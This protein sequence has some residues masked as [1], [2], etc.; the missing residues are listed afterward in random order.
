LSAV[1]NLRFHK[2]WT[3]CDLLRSYDFLKKDLVVWSC[4]KRCVMTSKSRNPHNVS[5]SRRGQSLHIKH[6]A[7]SR[8]VKEC[9]QPLTKCY[10]TYTN[11]RLTGQAVLNPD[12]VLGNFSHS[13]NFCGSRNSNNININNICS[14]T[15]SSKTHSCVFQACMTAHRDRSLVNKTNRQTEFQVY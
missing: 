1:M 10:D 14:E 6:F 2:M 15:A 13:Y 12:F 9:L 8:S 3:V 7:L 5:D 11:K 4:T